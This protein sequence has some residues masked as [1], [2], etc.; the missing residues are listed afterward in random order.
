MPA[1]RGTDARLRACYRDEVEATLYVNISC[2]ACSKILILFFDE[3]D[4]TPLCHKGIKG[5]LT[6]AILLDDFL[7]VWLFGDNIIEYPGN[8]GVFNIG[9]IA[10]RHVLKKALALRNRKVEN[11]AGILAGHNPQL[12]VE[13]LHAIAVSTGHNLKCP[14]PSEDILVLCSAQ[15]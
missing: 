1:L 8:T 15:R 13:F 14:H 10:A 12:L 4:M 9:A 2:Y 7:K 6:S 5:S 11:T 3:F